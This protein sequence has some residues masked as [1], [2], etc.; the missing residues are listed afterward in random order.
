MK[1]YSFIYSGISIY[2]GKIY[3]MKYI[4]S[5]AFLLICSTFTLSAQDAVDAITEKTCSCLKNIDH[6]ASSKSIEAELGICMIREAAP[7]E[8]E[9][10]KKYGI[11]LNKLDGPTGNK[12]GTLIGKK[13]LMKCPDLMAEL[14]SATSKDKDVAVAPVAAGGVINGTVT[15]MITNQFV[16]I[17]VSNAQGPDQKFLWMDFFQGA[18]LLKNGLA[19]IKGKS[20]EVRYT[21]SNY[22]NPSIKDYMKYKVLTGLSLK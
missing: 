17:T 3:T 9:L 10:K 19:D 5:L 2:L 6:A 21:E 8:K 7:Y 1:S 13:M 11:D 4:V 14:V 12:L 18:E 16:V 20:V 22:Y 15:D